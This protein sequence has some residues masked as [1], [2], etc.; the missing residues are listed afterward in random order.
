[1]VG[2]ACAQVNAETLFPHNALCYSLSSMLLALPLSTLYVTG[3]GLVPDFGSLRLIA[4]I[5]QE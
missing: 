2:G 4:I 5:Q 1:M 3:F